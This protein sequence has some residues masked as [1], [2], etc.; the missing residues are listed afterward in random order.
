[1]TK[2]DASY[3]LGRMALEHPAIHADY[4]AGRLT[5]RQA[6]IQ[7]GYQREPTPLTIMQREWKK[8]TNSQQRAFL[9]WLRAVRSAAPPSASLAPSPAGLA[10]VDSDG[11]IRDPVRKRIREVMHTRKLKMGQLLR[12]LGLNV[13]NPAIGLAL[14]KNYSVRLE[15]VVLLE[16]WLRDNAHI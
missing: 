16:K 8:A 1:M 15:N 7:A 2:R 12:E 10:V 9:L 5:A 6:M 3:Y 11:R 13:R 14:H 4:S